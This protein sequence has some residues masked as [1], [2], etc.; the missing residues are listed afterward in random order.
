M[1]TPERAGAG[2]GRACLLSLAGHFEFCCAP[3]GVDL[4]D[5]DERTCVF[6]VDRGVRFVLTSGK[7]AVRFDVLVS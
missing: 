3:G 6:A 1:A 5:A 7:P 2:L 4:V